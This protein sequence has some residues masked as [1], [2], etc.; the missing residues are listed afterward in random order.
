MLGQYRAGL[1]TCCRSRSRTGVRGHLILSEGPL[2]VAD[3]VGE[4]WQRES[5][6]KGPGVQGAWPD[7][8]HKETAKT[9]GRRR[10]QEAQDLRSETPERRQGLVAWDHG[11]SFVSAF[12]TVCCFGDRV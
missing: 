11:G 4:L 3:C 10:W 12:V 8:E 1:R 6:C 9:S 5:V 7:Q 2:S